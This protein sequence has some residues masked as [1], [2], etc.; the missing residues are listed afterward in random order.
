VDLLFEHTPPHRKSKTNSLKQVL[1]QIQILRSYKDG[2]MTFASAFLDTD[3]MQTEE[4]KRAVEDA[5][6]R[7]MRDCKDNWRG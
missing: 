5:K 6:K 4:I 1:M 7:Q 2:I 3:E